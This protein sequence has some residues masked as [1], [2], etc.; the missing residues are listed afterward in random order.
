MPVLFV[1]AVGGVV[2]T[3]RAGAR[4]GAATLRS[5]ALPAAGAACAV[6]PSLVFVYITPRYTADFLPFLM[7][8]AFAGLYAFER[9]AQSTRARRGLV[10][11]TSIVLGVLACW[12]VLANVSMA[13]DY[14]LGREQVRTFV[15]PER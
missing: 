11:V 2:A 6:V 7:L 3:V 4:V 8:L 1:L 14:Q 10:V 5:L 9:W 12:S 13:R 15:E